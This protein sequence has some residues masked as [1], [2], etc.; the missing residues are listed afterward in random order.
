MLLSRTMQEHKN[1]ESISACI[2]MQRLKDFY[3]EARGA[4]I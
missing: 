3:W 4:Y 1:K 2:Q